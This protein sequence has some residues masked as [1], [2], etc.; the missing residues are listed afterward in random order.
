M[1]G[2]KEGKK[3]WIRILGGSLIV[4]T[5][6]I[7]VVIFLVPF[8]HLGLKRAA[9]LTTLLLVATNMFWIGLALIGKE[10]ADKLR[11]LPKLKRWWRKLT[12]SG[13]VNSG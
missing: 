12:G 3:K 11:I 13:D 7:W 2:N 4:L 6:F 9:I 1:A 10:L 8:M 5:W